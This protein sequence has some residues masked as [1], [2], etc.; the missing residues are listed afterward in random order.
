MKEFYAAW[1]SEGMI[2]KL[3]KFML[4]AASAPQ[5]AILARRTTY[6]GISSRDITISAER[7]NDQTKRK[8]KKERRPNEFILHEKVVPIRTF[9]KPGTL[10]RQHAFFDNRTFDASIRRHCIHSMIRTQQLK[11]LRSLD[12]IRKMLNSRTGR[13]IDPE[14][15]DRCLI[16]P[17]SSLAAENVSVKPEKLS[18]SYK[19]IMHGSIARG[20]T[21]RSQRRH[22]SLGLMIALVAKFK[23]GNLI[24]FDSIQCEV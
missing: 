24:I 1:P 3:R 15:N 20:N 21:T 2:C 6:A 19:S 10:Q 11:L 8:N 13:K 4:S 12:T 14:K 9:R 17:E 22:D 5:S 16:N 7:S 18:A 23:A